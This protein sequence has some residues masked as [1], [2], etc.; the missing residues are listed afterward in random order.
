[1]TYETDNLV[2]AAY[3]RCSGFDAEIEKVNSVR[4]D[5]IFPYNDEL[6]VALRDLRTGEARVPPREF[7]NCVIELRRELQ[8]ELRRED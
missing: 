8:D 4:V 2:T 1:M 7:H 6:N 3:L 5:F